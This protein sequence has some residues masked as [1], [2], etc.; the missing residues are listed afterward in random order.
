MPGGHRTL[1]KR[2][3]VGGV[4]GGGAAPSPSRSALP[5]QAPPPPAGGSHLPTSHRMPAP[6]RGGATISTRKGNTRV[7][8][9]HVYTAHMQGLCS[10]WDKPGAILGS[11]GPSKL[12]FSPKLRPGLHQALLQWAVHRPFEQ[13]N[14]SADG[15]PS[16]K[17]L[18]RKLN[19]QT[20]SGPFGGFCP[21]FK[22]RSP[23]T[24]TP[25]SQQRTSRRPAPSIP[26]PG[27]GF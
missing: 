1:T 16:Q 9:F 3:L 15:T 12:G 20:S 18:S 7:N 25:R 23:A 26:S 13:P 14:S 27:S 6:E 21:S 2:P 10:P 22:L 4:G 24:A 5:H 19:P 11:P 17:V 8:N